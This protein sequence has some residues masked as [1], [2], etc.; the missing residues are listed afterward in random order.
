[1][2][3]LAERLGCSTATLYQHF[4]NRSALIIDVIDLVMAEVDAEDLSG[5]TWQQACRRLAN[6]TFDAL[7]RHHNVAALLAEHPPIGPNAMLLREHW[8]AVLLH[9]G[10]P[11]PL[12]A[13]TAVFLARY[14]LGFA[15]QL[16]APSATVIQLTAALRGADPAAFPATATVAGHLMKPVAYEF[17][18]GLDLILDGLTQRRDGTATR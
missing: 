9:H 17:D 10:F 15:T 11:P 18:F 6:A 4:S 7:N 2:R 14:T 8:L 1:M 16:V 12:A 3:T 5:A 13:D